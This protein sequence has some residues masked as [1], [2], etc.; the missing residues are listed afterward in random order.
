VLDSQGQ[1]ADLLRIELREERRGEDSIWQAMLVNDGPE[2]RASFVRPLVLQVRTDEPPERIRFLVNGYS[3]FSGSG[4]FSLGEAEIDSRVPWLRPV[5]RN[6]HL[7]RQRRPGHLT[8]AL[9]GVLAVPD[10]DPI[11]VGVLGPQEHFAQV[12]VEPQRGGLRL[13]TQLQFENQPIPAGARLSLPRIF[14]GRGPA[15]R[16]LDRYTQLLAQAWRVE[17]RPVPTGWCSW[18][19]YFTSIDERECLKNLDLARHLRPPVRIFQLDDGYQRELGDWLTPNAKFPSGLETLARRV[20]EAG[21]VPGI[22]VAPFLARMGSQLLREHP[23]W[24]LRDQ[25]GRRVVGLWNPNWGPLSFAYA[26]DATRP[27]LLAHLRNVFTTLRGYGFGFFKL[28]F[29]YAAS[30]PGAYH[31][32]SLTSLGALRQA[33]E[34]IREAVGDSYILGC[35]CPLEAGIGLVDSMRVGNDVT[36]YWSNSID[37]WIGRGFE[38]LSTRN[39]IRNT[40][41]RAP[42]NGRLF[43]SDPDCLLT[44]AEGNGLQPIEKRTLAQINALSGGTLMISD[45]LGTLDAE[46]RRLIE[47]AFRLGEEVRAVKRTYAAPDLMERRMPELQLALGP[48]DVYLGVYNFGQHPV[49]KT[50]RLADFIP[51]P[52]YTVQEYESGRHVELREG[53]LRTEAIEPHGTRLFRVLRAA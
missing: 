40:L 39:C 37:G 49:P 21:L 32:A 31:D 5:H 13:W 34:V 17:P 14:V 36:P 7:P 6:F 41:V 20:R 46:G 11:T 47:F 51:W 15:W 43:L 52:R 12:R 50:V 4:S 53:E 44:Q 3:S 42:L 35:G 45:D 23:D 18:Y 8:S 38:Q 29:L 48:E 16:V 2:I 22:W 24:L 28:D 27:E 26:L 10:Q 19:R 25:R 30:L 33:L 1:R 9:F